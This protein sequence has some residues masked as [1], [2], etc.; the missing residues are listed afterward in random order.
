M[1]FDNHP[2]EYEARGE[3]TDLGSDLI[4]ALSGLKKTRPSSV[5]TQGKQI[6]TWR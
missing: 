5:F 4:A 1:G 6:S 2:A 3:E